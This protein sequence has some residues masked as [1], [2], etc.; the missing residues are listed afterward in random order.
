MRE[1]YELPSKLKQIEW[2]NKVNQALKEVICVKVEQADDTS[3]YTMFTG[4]VTDFLT[5]QAMAETKEQ[6]KTR[7]PYY[8]KTNNE[9]LFRGED[10]Q[11]FVINVKQFKH[12]QPNEFHWL[13]RQM[14]AEAK[15]VRVGKEGTLRVWALSKPNLDGFGKVITY[16]SVKPDF[17]QFTEEDY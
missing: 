2:F 9:Y 7:K 11:N 16:E 13:Y 15:K 14:G 10:L 5:G 6:L 4:L 3:P 1:L 12:Y 8:D 17:T